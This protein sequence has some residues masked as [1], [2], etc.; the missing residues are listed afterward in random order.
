MIVDPPLLTIRANFPRPEARFVAAF[1]G[2]Q[3]GNVVDAMG[4]S[5]ALDF[6]IKPLEPASKVMVGV[7]LTCNCGPGDNLA[8][9]GALSIAE[10]GDILVAATGAFKGAAATGDLMLGMAHNRGIA[11]LVT[12]GL[13][14]DVAGALAVGLPVYCAGVSPNSPARNGPGT[15]G[16][17]ID[18]GGLRIE[19][20]D[21][22][23]GDRDGVVVV[24]RAR[25]AAVVE[26]LATVRAAEAAL[27]AKIVAG[28]QIPE[29]VEAIL[30]SD[31]VVRID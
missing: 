14:R 31:R 1:A 11:G 7:A 23:V 13:V 16:E 8:L 24:P 4:G 12:D 3:T 30:N 19:S 18:L 9:F 6:A 25:A 21:I 20:G 5:G 28:L 29:F 26:V 22:L 17:P 27:E 10:P 15:V 2:A